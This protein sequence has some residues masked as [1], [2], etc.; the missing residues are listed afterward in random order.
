[1]VQVGCVALHAQAA[2]LTRN[3]HLAFPH[4]HARAGFANTADINVVEGVD[5]DGDGVEERWGITMYIKSGATWLG[6]YRDPSATG[7][8]KTRNRPTAAEDG[9]PA[10]P[11]KLGWG[12]GWTY[13]NALYMS[14]NAGGGVWQILLDTFDASDNTVPVLLR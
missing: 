14:D 3:V 11:S 1:M 7:T 2:V 4:A 5:L 9:S 10:V 6:A 13:Q 12:A 8:Y